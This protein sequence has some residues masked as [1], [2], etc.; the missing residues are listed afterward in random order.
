MVRTA[1]PAAI[2]ALLLWSLLAFAPGSGAPAPDSTASDSTAAQY[3]GNHKCRICHSKQ[4]KSWQTT[5]HAA[6]LTNLAKADS[7]AI[8]GMA[9]K[10]GVKLGKPAHE[11]DDCVKCHVTGLGLAGGYP[12]ADS[13]S[14]ANLAA[15]GCESCHGPGSRHL[16]AAEG[17]HKATIRR[18]SP[19]TEKLCRTCH[20]AQTSPKF[21][22]AV[23]RKT[24]IHVLPPP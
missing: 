13:V 17:Q 5:V 15:V 3:I 18:G 19:E 24:G 14:R 23:Y 7:A 10:L 11:T 6:S 21:D 22:L 16:T 1:L 9:K 4:F 20:T 12:G 2:A 8:R